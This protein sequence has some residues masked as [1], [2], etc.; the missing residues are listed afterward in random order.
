MARKRSIEKYKELLKTYNDSYRQGKPKI[1]DEEFDLILEG[2]NRDYPDQYKEIRESLLETSGDFKHTFIAGSL[3]KI[4]SDDTK[5]LYDWINKTSEVAGSYVITPKL[6]GLSMV[7]YY[8]SGKLI[9]AVTRGDGYTGIVQTEKIKYIVPEKIDIDAS[10]VIRG[11][12]I[13]SKHGFKDYCLLENK[14]FKNPRNAAV[15]LINSLDS[16]IEK[17][18][19][20]S[21]CAYSLKSKYLESQPYD[22][23]L[24]KLEQ[25]GFIVPPHIDNIKPKQLNND[26]LDEWYDEWSDKETLFEYETD[27]V[28]IQSNNITNENCLLPEYAVAYKVNRLVAKSKIKDIEWNISKSGYFVPTGIIEPI[29]LGGAEINRV[30]LFNYAY[31]KKQHLGIGSEVIIQKSGDIIPYVQSVLT[32][33][34]D[35]KAPIE[36]PYCHSQLEESGV[37]LRCPNDDCVPQKLKRLAFLLRNNKV[38]V[39]AETSLLNWGITDIDKLLSFTPDPKYKNQIKFD[40]E[41]KEKFYT[42]SPKKLIACMDF[43]GVSIKTFKKL[44]R[45]YFTGDVEDFINVF[46]KP[47]SPTIWSLKANDI[48]KKISG[49]G[50]LTLNQIRLVFQNRNKAILEKIINSDNYKKYNKPKESNSVKEAL[51]N[52][53][54]KGL[55]FCFTGKLKDPRQMYEEIVQLNG[56]EVLTNVSKKLSYLVCNDESANSSK[57]IKAKELN[58]KIISEEQFLELC[59]KPQE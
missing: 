21:F 27:G 59:R 47:L 55:Y 2:L 48:E 38:E 16:S 57:L 41:L 43:D 13:F 46:G 34:E 52:D 31:V 12:C 58:I 49:I 11:E 9:Y 1:S 6:D 56:G 8:N 50:L 10:I 35:N 5:A 4:K 45:E 17:I 54:L 22:T 42:S 23:Q 14:D 18:K 19:C 25:N 44:F 15:G 39:A 51:S 24:K 26:L 7:L 53:S 29:V 40:N 30:T 20:L 37:E 3:N 28:V 32:N 36:C 33:S